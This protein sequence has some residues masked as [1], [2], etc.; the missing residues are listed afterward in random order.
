MTKVEAIIRMQRLEDV[1][2]AL[3]ALD[4]SGM[5]VTEVKGMGRSKG[6]THTYRGSQYTLSLTQ[7]IL[8]QKVT[9]LIQPVGP[10]YVYKDAYSNNAPEKFFHLVAP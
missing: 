10:N 4:I 8:W 7:P 5:T 9:G 3:T 2:D 1:Q 6:A